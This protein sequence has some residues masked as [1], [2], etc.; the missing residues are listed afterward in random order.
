MEHSK[1]LAHE[2]EFTGPL[3]Q[4]LNIRPQPGGLWSSWITWQYQSLRLQWHVFRANP[5]AIL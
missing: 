4:R 1:R 3:N 2:R 5:N